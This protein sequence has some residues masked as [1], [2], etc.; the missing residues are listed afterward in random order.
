MQTRLL[1]LIV[2]VALLLTP[3][4][5]AAGMS[6]DNYRISTTVMS[7]GGGPMGSANFQANGTTGQASPLID[8]LDPPYSTSYDLLTGF[9]Y[10]TG[11]GSGCQWDLE[12]VTGDG[13]VDGADLAEFVNAF[14]AG[15]V[16][17]FALVFGQADCF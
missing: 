5:A 7:G 14:S 11:A 15:D 6:S 3:G 12:P 4:L 8:P 17:S 1:T 13:D 9:W 16:E 10:T 2:L